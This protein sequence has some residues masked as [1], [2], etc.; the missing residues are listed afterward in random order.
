DVPRVLLELEPGRPRGCVAVRGR[1]ALEVAGDPSHGLVQ[2]RAIRGLHVLLEPDARGGLV[3]QGPEGNRVELLAHRAP[4]MPG[5]GG[6]RVPDD[7]SGTG[8]RTL[9]CPSAEATAGRCDE[10]IFT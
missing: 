9:P 8:A 3:G 5:A 1:A 6:G 4:H 7:T 10:I 2:R